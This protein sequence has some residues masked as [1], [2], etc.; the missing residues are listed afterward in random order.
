MSSSNPSQPSSSPSLANPLVTSS[1]KSSPQVSTTQSSSNF[2]SEKLLP[3]FKPTSSKKTTKKKYQ[4]WK[5][6][7]VWVK[8]DLLSSSN[9]LSICLF[10]LQVLHHYYIANIKSFKPFYKETPSNF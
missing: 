6:N 3:Q 2:S 4:Q 8:K 5:S 9:L 10:V 7:P 1:P